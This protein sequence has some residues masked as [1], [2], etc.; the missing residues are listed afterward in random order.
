[1]LLA[2]AWS[3]RT[4]AAPIAFTADFVQTRSLPGFDT[5]LVS[6]GELSFDPARGFRWEITSPY[7]YL[8]EMH[9]REASEQ[10]PDGTLRK[11]N[12]DQTP[13]LAAVEHIFV[14]AL[15]GDES[16]LQRYFQVN[17]QA[18]ARGRRVTLVP[19]PGPLA[20]AIVRIEVVESAPGRPE[21][22]DIR[23][24]S[25]GQMQIRFTPVSTPAA[26]P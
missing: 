26:T 7:H 24:A 12:P 19:K 5:P 16:E 20:D 8:F 23:E 1:M 17:V 3:A 22:L 4:A 18:L 11:L 6:H 21:Q 10:L 14:S 13:W 2:A 9:G 15:S 25:G